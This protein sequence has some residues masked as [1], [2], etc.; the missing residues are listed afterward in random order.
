MGENNSDIV[1]NHKVVTASDIDRINK[2][3]NI[4][5]INFNFCTIS[6]DNISFAPPLYQLI[7]AYSLV[8]YNSING[9]DGLKELEIVN[10]EEDEIE[11]DIKD[12]LKFPNIET[13]RIYNSKIINAKEITKFTNLKELYLDGST[14]D[15][16][17]FAKM[18]NESVKLSHNDVYLFD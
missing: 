12:L 10:D 14:V 6:G 18:L 13:L 8:D 15:V 3:G 9:L 16:E 5:I 1:I 4:E 17:D 7:F 11:V 2:Q